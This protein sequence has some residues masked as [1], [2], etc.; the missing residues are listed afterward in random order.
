MHRAA[1]PA[2]RAAAGWRERGISCAAPAPLESLRVHRNRDRG[3]SPGAEPQHLAAL[4]LLATLGLGPGRDPAARTR[5]N[6]A[7]RFEVDRRARRR[8]NR[9]LERPDQVAPR[10]AAAIYPLRLTLLGAV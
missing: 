4:R 7:L 8:V 10:Q 2:N 5:N 9:V 6:G 3:R 1:V